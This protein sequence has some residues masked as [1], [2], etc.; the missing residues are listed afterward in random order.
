MPARCIP[1]E[2]TFKA[3]SE[4]RVWQAL[5]KHSR[6]CD[7]LLANTRFVD[8]DGNWETDLILLMPEGFAT[9]EVKGGYVHRTQGQWLQETPNGVKRIDLD[10]QALS[11]MYLVRRYLQHRWSFGKPRM[12]HFVAL[13]D[14]EM[15]SDDPSPGLPRNRIITKTELK[16]AAGRV[17]DILTGPLHNEPNRPPGQDGVDA[18]ADLLGGA[19]DPVLDVQARIAMREAHL[20][21]LARL[22]YPLLDFIEAVARFDVTGGPGTGKTWLALEQTRRWAEDGQRVAYVCYSRGLATWVQRRILELPDKVARNIHAST[23]HALGVSWGA[24]VPTDSGPQFWE[25][26]LPARMLQ[27]SQKL[28]ESGRFDA[29]VVDEAQDFADSWWPP[30]LQALRHPDTGRIAVF[31]D[32]RQRIFGRTGKPNVDLVPLHLHRNLR[33]TRQIAGL[34]QPMAGAARPEVLAGN[35]PEVRFLP[36]PAEGAIEQADEAAVALLDQGWGT[37][38]VALLTTHHRHPVQLERQ[39][40]YGQD[41]YWESFWDASDLFYGTVLGFKG[42]ERPVVVLAVDGFRDES[43]A[44]DILYVGLSRARDLLVVCGDPEQIEAIAGKEVAKRLARS[45]G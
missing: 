7:V 2:P 21:D 37:D 36:C 4:R 11:E 26:D 5:R 44:R 1:A 45:V 18:A 42:L 43:V 27:L 28:P 16:D 9:I 40:H 24:D 22:Q 34:F 20:N 17:H 38:Q 13:P 12:A 14:T 23:F 32:D 30:L 15:G 10:E 25:E 29:L 19:A 41:G 8:E 39:E 33:N 31:G 6:E 35:G 3:E